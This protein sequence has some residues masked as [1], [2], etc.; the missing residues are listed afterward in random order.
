ML[1]GRAVEAALWGM[2]AV[3]SE[4]QFQ[5]LI[6]DAKG[7]VNQI[8]YW[9]RSSDWKNQ[10]LTPNTEF[11]YIIPF[12]NTQVAGPMVLEIPPADGGG[13]IVGTITDIWQKALADVGPMG[14]DQGEGGR[15]LVLPPGYE[16]EVPAGFIVVP[17][18]VFHVSALLRSVPRGQSDSDL[19]E[20]VSY[21]KN[22]RLYPLAEAEHPKPTRFID[23]SSI[24]FD[25]TI[26]YDLRYF[27]ALNRIVQN[28]PWLARDKAMIHLLKSIGIEQGKAFKP[29]ARTVEI[30]DCRDSG[31]ARQA[32]G[33]LH[34][35]RRF[36]L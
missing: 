28:E 6:R 35:W 7:D 30:L 2:P 9:S 34:L 27:Q 13:A 5:A 10:T 3:N 21:L 23:V 29:D 1:H 36:L 24:V 11:L 22:I 33:A 15:Y 31:S 20:A 18:E 14:L 16:G 8:V 19:S 25:A 26:P 17:T 4:I 12:I 32:R